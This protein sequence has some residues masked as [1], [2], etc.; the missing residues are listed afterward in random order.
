MGVDAVP[1]VD[2]DPR[3]RAVDGSGGEGTV[4]YGSQ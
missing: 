4:G 1:C 2:S 3:G